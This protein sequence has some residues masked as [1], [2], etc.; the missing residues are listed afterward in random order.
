MDEIFTIGD[1]CF[2]LICPESVSPPAHFMKFQGGKKPVYAY[3]I[4]V[5][6]R[7]PEPEGMVL[8][9][10]GD[11]LVLGQ[12]GLERRY[13]GVKGLPEPHA[14]YA[15]HSGREAGI[16]LAPHRLRSMEMDTMFS[17]LLALERR[18]M[19]YDALILH[20]AFIVHRGEAILFSAPSGTGKTTQADLW[21][22]HRG[23]E[24]VNGDR[25]LV[26]RIGGRWHARGWPVC[27][28]SG[29]CEN[30]DIPIR[31]VVMLSQA[32]RDQAAPLTPMQAFTQMYSQITVNR[33]NRQHQLRAMA[34]LEQLVA[35]VPVYHLACTMEP[36]AVEMLEKALNGTQ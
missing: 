20:C 17:S 22:R 34:V 35:A 13:I 21:T 9:Q 29:G 6:D 1:F 30:R 4:T 12:C 31:A 19:E 25:A 23:A 26:Q 32:S 5:S 7:F 36:S 11:I 14:C 2:R 24:T 33:W 18:Q 15:E 10:R 3:T 28:S 8:A 27:G 16:I